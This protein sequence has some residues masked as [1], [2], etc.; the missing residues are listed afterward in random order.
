MPLKSSIH[1]IHLKYFYHKVVPNG[2]FCSQNYLLPWIVRYFQ[3][4]RGHL[5]SC[6]DV[7]S[8]ERLPLASPTWRDTSK[9]STCKATQDLFANSVGR[10]W[11]PETLFDSTE[12]WNTV[13]WY[14]ELAEIQIWVMVQELFTLSCPTTDFVHSAHSQ[15]FPEDCYKRIYW[16][17]VGK[18]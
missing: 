5:I 4:W 16:N 9:R 7:P 10:R 1:F 17:Q 8:V 3:W 14:I 6:G 15:Q 13:K 12:S 2:C 11:R 18:L